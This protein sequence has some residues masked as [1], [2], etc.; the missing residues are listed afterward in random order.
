MTTLIEAFPGPA[1]D[2]PWT[3]TTAPVNLT[4][5]VD[6]EYNVISAN[7]S[8]Y[9][10]AMEIQTGIL[11]SYDGLFRVKIDVPT[12][13]VS[14]GN[15]MR[16]DVKMYA[17]GFS[18]IFKLTLLKW[19][20]SPTIWQGTWEYSSSSPGGESGSTGFTHDPAKPYY[21][22][23]QTGTDVTLYRGPSYGSVEAL[24]TIAVGDYWT[25]GAPTGYGVSIRTAVNNG[26][27]TTSRTIS[28]DDLHLVYAEAFPVDSDPFVCEWN[29]LS[30]PV[31]DITGYY[32]QSAAHFARVR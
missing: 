5:T 22:L 30:F 14:S 16:A 6:G 24:H 9:T 7:G 18:D 28:Y 1:L 13:T 3:V 23:I 26:A 21:Q 4:Y 29:V 15:V 19:D 27:A 8:A 10:D 31:Q 32:K 2:P 11:G 12:Y 25:T 20:V 17:P